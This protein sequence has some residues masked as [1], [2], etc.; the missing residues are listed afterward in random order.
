[1]TTTPLSQ[2]LSRSKSNIPLLHK[3][4]LQ[5]DKFLSYNSE[6]NKPSYIL[7]IKYKRQLFATIGRKSWDVERFAKTLF[8]FD[9]FPSPLKFFEN[10]FG[11]LSDQSSNE[12]SMKKQSHGIVLVTGATGGVGK[13]VVDVLREKGLPVRV[14]VRDKEKARKLLGPDI[15]LIVGDVTKENT[16]LP[17]YFKGVTKV[18]SAISVIIGPK[19]GDTSDRA[20]YRQGIKFFEPEIKGASPEMVEY[21]G[22]QNLINHVKKNVGRNSGKLLFGFEG[23]FFSNR[24]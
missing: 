16:L 6:K 18:I 21:I 10:M 1:G 15:D 4:Y 9:A 22:M 19:E 24:F 2:G 7:S 20:K 23:K 14:L 17:E 13:R 8:F 5:P 3:S 11:K 12:P